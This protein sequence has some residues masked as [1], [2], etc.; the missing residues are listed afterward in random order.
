MFVCVVVVVV[1]VVVVYLFVCRL[2]AGAPSSLK[3][4]LLLDKA[5]KNGF[6]YLSPLSLKSAGI[7]DTAD[8][9][10]LVQSMKSVR[11]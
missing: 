3:K 11:E 5:P 4:T 7:D 6:L 9:K 1:V 2:L 8:F 10:S